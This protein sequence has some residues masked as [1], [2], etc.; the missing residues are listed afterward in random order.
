MYS[1]IRKMLQK[2][3][4]NTKNTTVIRVGLKANTKHLFRL[5]PLVLPY[6]VFHFYL[7]VSLNLSQGKNSLR[8]SDTFHCNNAHFSVLVHM[9][10]YLLNMGTVTANT[11]SVPEEKCQLKSLLGSTMLLFSLLAWGDLAQVELMDFKVERRREQLYWREIHL[12]M[13]NMVHEWRGMWHLDQPP[14]WGS[15]AAEPT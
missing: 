2:H 8:S 15:A 4:K 1:I 9:H 7:Y 12:L 5:L 13:G 10:V 14:L 11:C 3:L 6:K